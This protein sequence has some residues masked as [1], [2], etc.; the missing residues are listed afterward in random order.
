[1]IGDGEG[2]GR[3]DLSATVQFMAALNGENPRR[4]ETVP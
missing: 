4:M 1:M 2:R 3:F